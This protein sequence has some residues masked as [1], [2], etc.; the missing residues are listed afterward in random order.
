MKSI[1]FVDDEV[2]V[3]NGLRTRLQ[4]LGD[5]WDMHFVDSGT[6]AVEE[7]ERKHFDVVVTDMRMPGMDG[8]QLLQIV[9]ERW[10]DAIRIVLSGYAEL[11]QV[12]RLAP[13]AHQYFGKPSQAGQLENLIGRCLNLHELLQRPALRAVV[14]RIR[15]L[16]AMPQIYAQLQ[17]LLSSDATSVRAI[18][19]LIAQ[20]A[21]IA[22]K[23]LQL[24]NS[25]FFRLSR[26]I[27][28]IE[29]AVNHLGFAA[30]RNLVLSA[31]VFSRWSG[32]DKARVNIDKLQAHV[33]LIAAGARSL[34][35]PGQAADDALLAGLLHDIGYWILAQECTAELRGSVEIATARRIPLH[36][37]ETEVIGASHAQIGAYLLGLWGLPY[38]VIE[39]VAYHHT[40]Q[41]VPPT[42][43]DALAALA[44]AHTLVRK[45]DTEIFDAPLTP[46]PP[47]NA[48]YLAAVQAPFDW[49]E[50]NRRVAASLKSNGM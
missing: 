2:P 40:P 9:S 10:P 14:G 4:G 27:T 25:A 37:A 20:D 26:R 11:Q 19:K 15:N 33:Q 35:P 21:A 7:L 43:F 5:R 22:A 45:D 23:V 48:A 8:A 49:A 38:T 32:N 39:A 30:I 34:E 29:Q 31:E 16:P 24:V 41:I 46:D 28:N 44:V 36:E 47:V 18:S 42:E 50:A 6:R 1:L 3:L 17:G 13:F 12:V